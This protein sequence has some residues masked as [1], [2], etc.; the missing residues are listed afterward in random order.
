FLPII[1]AFSKAAG[2][3]VELRDISLAGRILAMFPDYLTPQQ[4]QA[5]ALSELGELAKRPEANI[6]KLPNVSASLPQLQAAIKEL[7]SQ[8]Y[9]LPDYPENPKDDKEKDIKNRYDKVK[10]SAVNP[11]LR[12]GNS[13]RRA[14]LSVKA[15]T[16]KHPHKMGAWSPDSKTHV[17]HMKGGDFRSNEKSMTTTAAT[18]ARIEFVGQDGK[19]TVLKPKVALQA[20]EIIDATFMSKRALRQFLEEQ[21]EDAKK[22]GVLFSIHMK[23]TMMKISDPKIFGHAV[24]VYYKDVFEKHGETLKKLGVDPDNG[25]GDL[26]AK[27]KAL[28]DDQRKA[29]EADI[30]EVY[31][32]RPPMAMVNSDK[33]IT[34][35][36]VPSDIIIDASIPPV[37]RDSGKMWNPEGKLQDT[38]VVIPDASYAPVYHEVIEFC[39]KNGAFDP[40]TM[41]S[42]PNVGLMAQ[43]AEEYGSHDKTFKAPGNGTIRVVDASGKSLLEHQ[44][45]EGDI[46]RMCQVKDAPIRD[47]VKLAVNRAKATGA[48]AIFWLDKTRAHDAQLITKVERYL[49]DHDTK[50]L[51]IRIMTPADA[52]RLSLERIKEGKDTISVTGNVLRDYLT[53]LFPILEI[54]TSAK[55][56]SIVP[57]L[58][59]GGLFETGAGGSAPK[60]V[61]QFQEEG[62]LRWDS[63]GEFLALAASLE[64]LAKVANNQAAKI[65]ADSLDQANAKFLESNKSPARKVGEIDNRGSHFYLALYWAQAL[66]QQTQDKNLAT[67]FAKIAKDMADNEA[68]I[69]S[70]L[71]GA[72]GKPVDVGGYYHPDDA[73]ASKAMRPSPT[74]N[75]IV[76]A[77]A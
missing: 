74:L 22:Q 12:E 32:K 51:D 54:G 61:Q 57:L 59:G 53:D 67:R 23:A 6:I 34:N 13:D 66:A 24:T 60:H 65:L 72:Q 31:K 19:T 28:P 37:I 73:K 52:T 69:S 62:Y 7:Q 33:G 20:N 58:N 42:V 56:L 49:K 38:K 16:R 21:I 3:S 30:Q 8:G 4:K 43:A 41:G 68:K 10:G 50:G 5:D 14:P 9:K 27:I 1:N 25:I 64:H 55:M 46:W 77:I 17:A 2:V 71:L 44:V 48:P 45:E 75:A 35:L 11:V 76:D 63:L 18:D 29:I 70:E 39:K 40:K 36:H 47:W 26:Y 15:H